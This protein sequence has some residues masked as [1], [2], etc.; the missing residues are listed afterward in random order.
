MGGHARAERLRVQ[1]CGCPAG[2][3]ACHVKNPKRSEPVAAVQKSDRAR[4][5]GCGVQRLVHGVRVWRLQ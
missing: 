1:A 3:A 5:G 4:G 2:E